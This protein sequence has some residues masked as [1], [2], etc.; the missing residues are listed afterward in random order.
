MRMSVARVSILLSDKSVH[1][2]LGGSDILLPC[3]AVMIARHTEIE[4]L[5]M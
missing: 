1:I 5:Y 4:H 3:A 2:T